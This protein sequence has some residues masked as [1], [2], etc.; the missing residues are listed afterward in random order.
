[1]QFI[2]PLSAAAASG[3]NGYR[4]SPV[5][6]DISVARGGSSQV[7]VYI[8]NASSAAENLQVVVD[9]FEAPT[10]QSGYPA[11]L[12]NGATA[13]SHSLKQFVTIP[14]PTLTLQPN[15]QD[16]VLVNINVPANA[17]SGG[18]YGAIRFAPIT[19][20]ANG[21]KNVNLSASVASL[22]LL[23]VPGALQEQVNVNSFGISQGS[24]DQ[25]KTV[26]YSNK[27]LNAIVRFQNTGNVQEQPFGNIVIKKG[28]KE[29][30]TFAVNNADVPGNVL[31]SSIRLFSVK[32]SKVGAFGE[33][34]AEG[35]FGY[36]SQGQ[37][38]TATSTFYVVPLAAIVVIVLVII[39]IL[40]LIFG[41]PRVIRA[42]NRRVISRSSNP[43]RR[44]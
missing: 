14:N 15:Q 10:N 34:K 3:S 28:N 4:L 5:R 31:P 17:I 26:F 13:P 22:V 33:Y 37:L 1:M 29:L 18:Y 44:Q 41:L 40:F 30:G 32:I 11:L 24:S 36:G 43:K 35:N 39:L 16:A 12:L 9:D 7:T 38:L 8:Q 21:I 20:S 23:T 42:Y 6:T 25:T 27:N 19:V 2:A